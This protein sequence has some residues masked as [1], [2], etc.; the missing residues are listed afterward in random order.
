MSEGGDFRPIGLGPGAEL[1]SGCSILD[2]LGA[3]AFG[4]NLLVEDRNF[5][6]KRIAVRL[7][8]PEAMN[9]TE[10]SQ[11][12]FPAFERAQKIE[13]PN[14]VQ[15]LFRGSAPEFKGDYV[16]LEI[17]QGVTLREF[18][19][20]EQGF[21]LEE[22]LTILHE[23]GKGLSGIHG[24]NFHHGSLHP[25]M[26]F[27]SRE[28]EVKI[29]YCGFSALSKLDPDPATCLIPWRHPAFISPEE[30]AGQSPT[31]ASDMYAFGSIAFELLTG[32]LAYNAATKEEAFSLI[33]TVD[34]PDA[35]QINPDIPKYLQHIIAKSCG[36]DPGSRYSSMSPILDVL[37]Q[38][39][40]TSLGE[41]ML[42]ELAEL[43][44]G[45]EQ[46]K[47]KDAR[48]SPDTVC[49]YSLSPF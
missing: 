21:T 47:R 5:G 28:G 37:A 43:S 49:R 7:F 38:H 9:R 20:G 12:F 48:L 11:E 17:M 36:R 40:P 31:F 25:G 34:F 4:I 10:V 32:Q 35:G 18:I 16:A 33:H 41:E 19:D 39:A 23:V 26:V 42:G 1:D 29:N 2:I 8:S 15:A 30:V 45:N 3:D 46:K 14:V 22:I 6:G 24:S 13:H 44:E 27:I